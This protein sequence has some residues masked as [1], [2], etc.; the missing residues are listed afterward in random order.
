M[1]GLNRIKVGEFSIKQ[2]ISVE[3]LQN[4]NFDYIPIEDLFKDKNE[5]FLTE[6]K[7][8]LFLN[9]VMLSVDNH[10]DVYKIYCKKQFV[11]TGVVKNRITKT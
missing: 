10:E 6:K 11:G 1:S 8:N 9:G 3:D 2:A 4:G 7:L 5:I